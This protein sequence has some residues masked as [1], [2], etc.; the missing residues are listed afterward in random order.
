MCQ[1]AHKEAGKNWKTE[2]TPIKRLLETEKRAKY[3]IECWNKL[4]WYCE[5]KAS[6][7][8]M[9][10]IIA[11]AQEWP[12]TWYLVPGTLVHESM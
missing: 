7:R 6:N 4:L 12:K 3:I 9:S 5:F 10:L 1:A 8:D 2:I 11:P